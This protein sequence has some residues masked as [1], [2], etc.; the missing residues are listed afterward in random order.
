MICAHN[1]T[2][3]FGSLKGLTDGD[4]VIFTDM[5]G[6]VWRYEVVVVDVLSA[7]AVEEMES[8]EYDLTLF[9]C[10]YDGVSRVTVRCDRVED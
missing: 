3:H 2:Q 4:A 5:D 8:G 6:V 9:T 10:T 7:T 1:Y